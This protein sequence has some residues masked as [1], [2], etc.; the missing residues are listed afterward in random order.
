MKKYG[1]VA[2]F[3]G[4][5]KKKNREN[6]GGVIRT[7]DGSSY[8]AHRKA[9]VGEKELDEGDWVSF[10]T[11]EYT[12]KH[13]ETTIKAQQVQLIEPTQD[14]QFDQ[15]LLSR[16]QNLIE[17]ILYS[18]F[19]KKE[20]ISYATKWFK[21]WID[22]QSNI[23]KK[24]EGKYFSNHYYLPSSFYET[25]KVIQWKNFHPCWGLNFLQKL[26]FDI[27]NESQQHIQFINEWIEKLPF[28]FIVANF[29]KFP[30]WLQQWEALNTRIEEWLSSASI[31]EQISYKN[32]IPH[33]LK[34]EVDYWHLL[35]GSEFPAAFSN[36]W[37]K[38]QNNTYLQEKCLQKWITCYERIQFEDSW[39]ESLTGITLNWALKRHKYKMDNPRNWTINQVP[40]YMRFFNEHDTVDIIIPISSIWKDIPISF[41]ELLATKIQ[42]KEIHFTIPF[43][44]W[45][46]YFRKQLPKETSI[47][48]IKNHWKNKH[49]AQKLTF[50]ALLGEQ[51]FYSYLLHPDLG[52]REALLIWEDE[53]NPKIHLYNRGSWWDQ[54]DVIGKCSW[55]ILAFQKG[56][57]NRDFIAENATDPLLQSFQLLYKHYLGIQPLPF[58]QWHSL[59][60]NY[61]LKLAS[62][63][64]SKEL[65]NS[66]WLW[67][68]CYMKDVCNYCEGKP[69]RMNGETTETISNAY[70]PRTKDKCPLAIDA[71]SN[72]SRFKSFKVKPHWIQWRMPEIL[73]HLNI[74]PNVGKYVPP[75]MYLTK[76]G[77]WLNRHLEIQE[78]LRC[79]KCHEP[80]KNNF[81]YSKKFT[82]KFSMTV[83]SCQNEPS[84]EHDHNIYIN[85]CWNTDDCHQIIDSRDNT[86]I[87]YNGNEQKK[88]FHLCTECG[89][90]RPPSHYPGF[91]GNQKTNNQVWAMHNI[92]NL[93]EYWHYI[94]GDKCPK[95]GSSNMERFSKKGDQK[96]HAECQDCSHTIRVPKV[97]L[98]IIDSWEIYKQ[99]KQITEL[100]R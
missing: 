7:S 4:Y 17:S 41:F 71:D 25:I 64:N 44:A 100:N 50:F 81:D 20:F 53:D 91:I 11:R 38:I 77:G 98:P 80:M 16:E 69:W 28:D 5:N 87:D 13:G 31:D 3:G 52:S 10:I 59:V 48:W 9:V 15:I 30:D 6:D 47:C 27:D 61:F 67:P 26:D 68:A 21:Q 36:Y 93:F 73:D 90:S 23:D 42:K 76:F 97:F 12:T 66:T 65:K 45:A 86:I 57:K 35:S 60:E 39:T 14:L 34:Q 18:A 58:Q 95:C 70:C 88:G 8:F 75:H 37:N 24:C 96:T 19:E 85:Q 84:L 99:K 92:D 43:E 72:G 29:D 74:T 78:R 1:E 54:L 94:P 32:I 33:H 63:L 51:W 40:E 46:L 83:A 82:A 79:K 62:D 55:F 22:F 89:A 49:Q 2:W 56:Y